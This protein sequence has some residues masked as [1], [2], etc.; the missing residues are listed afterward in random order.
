MEP[1]LDE[2]GEA[3]GDE[4]LAKDLYKAGELTI[5]PVSGESTAER[6]HDRAVRR[7]AGNSTQLWMRVAGHDPF[8]TV[9][10]RPLRRKT[11]YADGRFIRIDHAEKEA[12][13]AREPAG[14]AGPSA[15]RGNQG[16]SL[17]PQGFDKIPTAG[18]SPAPPK[19]HAP[20]P[21][22]PR[23]RDGERAANVGEALLPPGFDA[24]PVA[25]RPAPRRPKQEPPR[26][27]PPIPTPSRAK[28]P[29]G[30]RIR[31]PPAQ[32][33]GAATRRRRI[34][35]APPEPSPVESTPQAP[36]PRVAPPTHMGLDDLFG[37]PREGRAKLK[38]PTPSDDD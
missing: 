25:K 17:L 18:A 37:A 7:P 20:S 26:E 35:A 21:P 8:D 38:Q 23:R 31:Q 30:G 15:P 27:A 29:S 16:A 10:P 14:P 12:A 33:S 5:W 24:I 34:I 11:V 13:R 9:K 2:R 36:T 1:P 28:P 4:P 3:S 19:K 22:P 6:L 32:R